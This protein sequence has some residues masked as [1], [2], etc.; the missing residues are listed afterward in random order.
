MV[1]KAIVDLYLNVKIRSQDQISGMTED[2]IEVEKLKLAKT[3]TLDIIDYIKQSI[4]ILM[5]M[6]IE[7]FE[8][9]QN[10]WETNEKIKMSKLHD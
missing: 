7:E 9:F 6:R 10:N 3:D 1:R 8:L 5:H 2:A 4:E